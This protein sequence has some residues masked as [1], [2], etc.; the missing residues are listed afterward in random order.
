MPTEKSTKRALRL[1]AAKAAARPVPAKRTPR[2]AALRPRRSNVERSAETRSALIDAAIDILYREGHAAATTIEVAARADVSRGGMQHQFPTRTELLLA[3]ARHIVNEQRTERRAKIGAL[4]PGIKRYYAAGDINWEVHK[5]PGTI[6]F[7]EIMMATRSDA[8][9]R[10][11]FAPFF[12]E[13]REL[14]SGGAAILAKDLGVTSTAPIVTMLHLHHLVL[15][16]MA[17]EML[18]TD[19]KE[20]VEEARRLFRHYSHTYANS[21]VAAEQEKIRTAERKKR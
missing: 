19:D 6:A 2:T 4:E 13:L 18:F 15:R 12:K 8:H 11:G 14:R 3:V 17:I 1:A 5:Q 21:L 9:L 7:L 20:S 16:G 10:K